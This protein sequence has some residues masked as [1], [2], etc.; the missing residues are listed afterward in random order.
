MKIQIRATLRGLGATCLSAG[1]LS[2]DTFTVHPVPGMGDFVSPAEALASPLVID[3]DVIL[4]M[5][6]TYV[7]ALLVD[8]AV[9]LDALSG[10]ELTVLDG[11]GSAP[12]VE[13]AAG[14]TVRGFSIT[15]GGG[16]ASVGGVLVTSD[17]PALLEENVIFENHPVGDV[18]IPGGGVVVA[19]GAAAELH[20]NDI[21][22]NTSLSVGGL[23][24]GPGTT[25]ELIGNRIRGNGGSGTITGGVLF[26]GSGRMVNVQI[27]GNHGS[28]VGGLYFAGGI[29]PDPWGA[30]LEL[31]NCTIFGNIGASLLGSSGGLFLDDGGGLTVRNTIIH[32]NLGTPGGDI[33]ISS[34]FFAPPVVG[35]LDLDHSHVK[36][37]GSGV[38]PGP[39][40]VPPLLDPG[41]VDPVPALPFGPTLAGDYHL[42]PASPEVDAGLDAAFPADLSPLDLSRRPRFRGAAVDVGAYEYVPRLLRRPTRP[43]LTNTV[44]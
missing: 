2:A 8:K 14:A 35:F 21:H 10:P 13:L 18:G 16:F 12:V 5:P 39:S 24:A 11:D 41:F 7:G 22:S 44:R 40:M 20:W 37:A 1:A 25:V 38:I 9:V 19:A 34:D 26:G 17:V 4:V 30:T 15:G 28:G 6:G 23:L 31:T 42:T 43:P 36:T 33:L 27:T 29:G 3:G 32:S